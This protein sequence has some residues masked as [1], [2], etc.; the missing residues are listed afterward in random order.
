MGRKSY[1]KGKSVPK[2]NRNLKEDANSYR[3]TNNTNV[4]AF[5]ESYEPDELNDN[6]YD[7][8][9]HEDNKYDLNDLDDCKDAN[10]HIER[11]ANGQH[12]SDSLFSAVSDSPSGSEKKDWGTE[13]RKTSSEH[14]KDDSLRLPDI[15]SSQS[16]GSRS[17][18]EQLSQGGES[19]YKGHSHKKKT[20]LGKSSPPVEHGSHSSRIYQ[21]EVEDRKTILRHQKKSNDGKLRHDCGKTDPGTLRKSHIWNDTEKQT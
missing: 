10:L 3:Q 7:V 19:K 16:V 2:E 6:N 11:K 1:I 12:A 20:S 5:E 18:Y 14:D 4:D 21:P 15:N 8:Y 9:E 17:K 13:T